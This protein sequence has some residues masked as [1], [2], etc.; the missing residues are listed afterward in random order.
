MFDQKSI[1]RSLCF[2][3]CHNFIEWHKDK[4]RENRIWLHYCLEDAWVMWSM[5][6][7]S[8]QGYMKLGRH[9]VELE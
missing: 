7:I 3:Y 2:R 9:I 6:L 8:I 4:S 1:R 5:G